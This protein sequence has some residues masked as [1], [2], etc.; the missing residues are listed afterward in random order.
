MIGKAVNLFHVA[1]LALLCSALGNVV[2]FITSIERG[3]LDRILKFQ[4][5]SQTVTL[6]AHD[7]MIHDG[8]L[9]DLLEE[10]IVMGGNIF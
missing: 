9:L 3:A 8:T 5:R 6:A 2:M 1:F 4:V 10:F 7:G